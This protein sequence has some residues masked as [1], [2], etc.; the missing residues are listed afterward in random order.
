MPDELAGIVESFKEQFEPTNLDH[1]A[2]PSR[3][4][5]GELGDARSNKTLATE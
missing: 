1:E 5:A 4:D 3:T 2:D